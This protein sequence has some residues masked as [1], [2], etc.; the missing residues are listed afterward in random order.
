MCGI[1]GF[2]FSNKIIVK[3]MTNFLKHRGPDGEGFYIDEN[4]SL[5]HRRL[6][7]IDLSV[8][9]NQPMSY[10]DYII[11]YNGEIYNFLEL[12]K[13]LILKGHKFI[14]DSDTEVILHSYEEWGS[15]CVNYFNG[16][17]AFCIYDKKKEE[18]FLSRDRFGIKPLYYYWDNKI[19]IFTSELKALRVFSFNLDINIK[20][21]NYYFYQKYIGGELT[22]FKNIYKLKPSMNLHFG[23]N[24]KKITKEKYYF[25]E[26]EIKKNEKVL[27]KDR[28]YMIDK[29][30]KD[31]VIKRL[32]ADVPVGS[33]LSGGIDSSLISAIIAKN[34]KDFDTFSIGFNEATYD[35][36]ILKLIITINI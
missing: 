11:V 36:I 10:K 21:L 6:S 8:K 17:W 24:D 29:I 4:V 15:K 34:K 27:L 35:E 13:E 19:F 32:I 7:I 28:L 30:L 14:S 3:K 22:I 20:A 18:F 31:A 25:L 23:I 16:M 9:G 26:E 2:N 5:G 12:K 1:V 33:F